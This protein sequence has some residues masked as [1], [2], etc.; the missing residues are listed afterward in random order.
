M[1]IM[2]CRRRRASRTASFTARAARW[3]RVCC[4]H[5]MDRRYPSRIICLTEEPTEVL[6]ALGMEERIVGISGFTVR[7]ARA[8]REKPRVS[9]FTSGK[10]RANL[11]VEA[12][13]RV[14]FSDNP[15]GYAAAF[16][17]KRNQS[18]IHKSPSVD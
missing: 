17:Q 11:E 9:A 5:R 10:S 14:R 18:L 4:K 8:R 16:D 15:G 7:P 1:R 3:P 13:L 12:G 2:F 6:Y